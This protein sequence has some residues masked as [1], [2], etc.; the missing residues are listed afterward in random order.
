M[1][2][3]TADGDAKF[4]PPLADSVQLQLSCLLLDDRDRLTGSLLADRTI[5]AAIL[6]DLV[7]AGALQNTASE[8]EI[9]QVTH[10]LP[11]AHR[12]LAD[13]T[14]H[15]GRDLI[16]WAHHGSIDARDAAEQMVDLGLWERHT[17][18]LGLS[19][20]YRWTQ[21]SDDLADTLRAAVG[22]TFDNADQALVAPHL[23]R[24]GG[25]YGR[26]P[27]P[28]EP[29]VVTRLAQSNW[30]V[31]DLIDYLWSAAASAHVAVVRP[32]GPPQGP[33]G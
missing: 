20:R 28:P 22:T 13:M 16:W 4:R 27:W 2:L 33:S 24:I 30:L 29:A 8:I 26:K 14:D 1:T 21:P 5:R 10:L 19:H 31:P 15:P 32:A 17:E 23:A 6:I 25:L 11:L 12:M 3:R 18:H 7:T 9:R